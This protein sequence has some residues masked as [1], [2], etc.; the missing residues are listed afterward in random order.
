MAFV[1]ATIDFKPATI[2]TGVKC[3]LRKTKRAGAAISFTISE[4]RAS[5][6]NLCDGD[7]IEVLIG[8]GEHHGLVRMRKH[9]IIGASDNAAN[10]KAEARTTGKGAFYLIKLGHQPAFVD[11]TEAPAWC[12]WEQVEDGWLE[13][14]LPK[15]ADETAPKGK[16]V[17]GT[18]KRAD[19]GANIKTTH[20]NINTKPLA[21]P[22]ATA[23]RSVTA[24]LMGDPAPGRREMMQKMGEMKP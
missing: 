22:T 19:G 3:S 15:W 9:N 24:S 21:P 20:S 12:Q 13:I 17:F 16:T 7:G 5:A 18:E 6:M 14:V 11:R 4:A 8:E 10:T 1:K 23:K 2:G